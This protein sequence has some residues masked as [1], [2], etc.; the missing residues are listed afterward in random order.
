MPSRLEPF[1]FGIS[2]ARTGPG[3]YDPDDIRFHSLKRLPERSPSNCSTVTPSAPADPPF[4]LT[5]NHA[6]H[7]NRLG[8]TYDFPSNLGSDMRFLPYG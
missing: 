6:S 8:M 1:F 3:K 7:T 4:S 2:T 5:F